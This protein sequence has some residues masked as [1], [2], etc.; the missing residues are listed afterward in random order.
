MGEQGLHPC[1]NRTA[2]LLCIYLLSLLQN[3]SG[4][5]G[6][7]DIK[8]PPFSPGVPPP[9]QVR[10]AC[11]QR[12][13]ISQCQRLI[14]RKGIINYLKVIQTKVLQNTHKRTVLPSPSSQSGVPYLRKEVEVRDSGSQHHPH[15]KKGA[16]PKLH[17]PQ[18]D[19][20][21]CVVPERMHGPKK[22]RQMAAALGFKSQ[23]Q[24]SSAAPFLAPPTIGHSGQ[25][26]GQVRPCGVEPIIF[27]LFWASLQIPNWG[28][29]LGCTL[30]QAYCAVSFEESFHGWRE[31]T[32]PLHTSSLS[33]S[34]VS[35]KSLDKVP[36]QD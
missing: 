14:K 19:A 26:S 17:G 24:S 35:C 1:P 16:L 5:G 25:H 34:I 18:K 10:L 12:K 2:S 33:P 4:V 32:P 3:R 36:R 7:N 27:N 21:C 28:P 8:D 31:C 22:R 30:L 6:V 29:L 9:Y 20:Q 13:D 11:L 23:L 15:G